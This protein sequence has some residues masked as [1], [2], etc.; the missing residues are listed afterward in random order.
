MTT[1]VP[2]PICVPRVSMTPGK[3]CYFPQILGNDPI[4]T[5]SWILRVC[6]MYK[7][8]P[9][10]WV[11]C[12]YALQSDCLGSTPRLFHVLRPAPQAAG[13][14]LQPDVLVAIMG[15]IYGKEAHGRRKP[16]TPAIVDSILGV[17]SPFFPEI[18]LFRKPSKTHRNSWVLN[19][20]MVE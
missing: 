14:D 18:L 19:R 20:T 2:P 10:N 11:K 15:F 12:W 6:N 16:L 9:S 17:P 1:R 4:F 5:G 7:D 3:G 8:L 13:S